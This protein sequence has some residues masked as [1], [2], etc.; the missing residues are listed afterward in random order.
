MYY[1]LYKT[2]N[3]HLS[4]CLSV[5][6]YYRGWHAAD[7]ASIVCIVFLFTLNRP[8]QF[9]YIKI[10]LKT[11]VLSTKHLDINSSNSLANSQSLLLRYIVLGWILANS[12]HR[13]LARDKRRSES[14]KRFESAKKDK[15]LKFI[16]CCQILTCWRSYVS[17]KKSHLGYEKG[18]WLI[19]TDKAFLK[20]LLGL[21]AVAGRCSNVRKAR[22]EKD[23]LFTSPVQTFFLA[24]LLVLLLSS[25]LL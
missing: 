24:L 18:K 19:Q 4:V 21:W 5:L 11:I 6:S 8:I 20:N 15:N 7:I 2:P 1:L 16:I 10:Q 9:R 22:K 14:V 25:S 13:S 23:P 3:K 12:R 17:K